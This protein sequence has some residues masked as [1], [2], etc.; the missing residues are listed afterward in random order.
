MKRL[1]PSFRVSILV[2]AIF[3]AVAVPVIFCVKLSTCF[4]EF[5]R[6][7]AALAFSMPNIFCNAAARSTGLWSLV[8]PCC[9]VSIAFVMPT[10]FGLI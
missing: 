6:T 2:A 5:I 7:V 8:K 1:N 9:K 10:F 3:W 4:A